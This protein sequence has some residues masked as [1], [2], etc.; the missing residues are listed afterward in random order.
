MLTYPGNKD[1]KGPDIKVIKRVGERK[2]LVRAEKNEKHKEKETG[3]EQHFFG[4]APW[5]GRLV[6][7]IRMVHI[8]RIR[9]KSIRESS[10]G[11]QH[12]P[13]SGRMKLTGRNGRSNGNFPELT[14][15]DIYNIFTPP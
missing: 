13:I 12:L 1:M 4:K 5:L 2:D 10:G 7:G 15:N 6:Q 11:R 14:D 9:A 3:A 8:K